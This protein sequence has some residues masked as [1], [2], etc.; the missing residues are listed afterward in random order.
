MKLSKSLIMVVAGAVL[1][2]ALAGCEKSASKDTSGAPTGVGMSAPG[3]S[4]GA[5]SAPK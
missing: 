1:C 3:S 2:I 4:T 5:P